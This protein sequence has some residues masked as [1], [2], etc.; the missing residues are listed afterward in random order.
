MPSSG[1]PLAGWRLAPVGDGR[2]RERRILIGIKA[3]ARLARHD[4]RTPMDAHTSIAMRWDRGT[5]IAALA[6]V[7]QFGSTAVTVAGLHMLETIGSEDLQ[8]RARRARVALAVVE[9]Q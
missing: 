1:L 6:Y 4:C 3:R 2:S 7:E 8:E 5:W 9:L